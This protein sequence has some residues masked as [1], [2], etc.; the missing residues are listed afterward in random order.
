MKAWMP[1]I[2]PGMTTIMDCRVKPAHDEGNL[3]AGFYWKL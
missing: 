2:K 3:S 1:G